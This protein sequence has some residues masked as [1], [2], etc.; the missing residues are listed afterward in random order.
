MLQFVWKKLST[1][2][3][4]NF[5][6]FSVYSCYLIDINEKCSMVRFLLPAVFLNVA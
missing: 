4:G 2:S 6:H 5:V 1:D 3:V